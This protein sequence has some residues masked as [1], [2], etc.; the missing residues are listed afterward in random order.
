VIPFIPELFR[1]ERLMERIWRARV[2]K[3][4]KEAQAQRSL[5]AFHAANPDNVTSLREW[6]MRRARQKALR[7]MGARAL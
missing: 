7:T 2:K 3:N 1:W 4:P 5:A 6:R